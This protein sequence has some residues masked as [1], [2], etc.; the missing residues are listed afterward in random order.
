MLSPRRAVECPASK[1]KTLCLAGHLMCFSLGFTGDFRALALS[2]T[3]E[4]FGLALSL[5][6]LDTDGFGRSL[7]GFLYRGK[8]ALDNLHAEADENCELSG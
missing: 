1:L 6:G 7:G 4:F 5:T 8:L 3:G 2:F